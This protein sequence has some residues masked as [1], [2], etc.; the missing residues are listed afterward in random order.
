MSRIELFSIGPNYKNRSNKDVL[1]V[2]PNLSLL[3]RKRLSKNIVSVV[4]W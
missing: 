2:K 3:V 4:I 1:I